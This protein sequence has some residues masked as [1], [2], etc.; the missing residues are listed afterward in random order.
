MLV[1]FDACEFH[2]L[3]GFETSRQLSWAFLSS[4][5][6]CSCRLHKIMNDKLK[7][8]WN[9]IEVILLNFTHLLLRLS[10]F[11]HRHRYPPTLQ[12][13]LSST[14]SCLLIPFLSFDAKR[15]E[16]WKLKLHVD[17]W[18][19]PQLTKSKPKVYVPWKWTKVF[20]KSK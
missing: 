13:M 16:W 8:I 1:A 7:L 17:S 18:E 10:K 14:F 9:F 11:L 4:Y 12:E 3:R 19:N 6:T 5:H 2:S 15:L 20:R